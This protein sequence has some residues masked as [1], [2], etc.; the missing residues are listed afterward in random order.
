MCQYIKTYNA[1]PSELKNNKVSITQFYDAINDVI[2]TTDPN[3]T[4]CI[5][6]EVVKQICEEQH[7]E[8]SNQSLT[9]L[10]KLMRTKI[11]TTPRATFDKE[12]RKK[13]MKTKGSVVRCVTMR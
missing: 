3:D 8:F 4:R 11:M 7:I 5:N 9:T 13:Y 10:I 12:F 1:V 2:I 6:Y